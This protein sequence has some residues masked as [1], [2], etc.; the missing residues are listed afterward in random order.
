M[1]YNRSYY[2]RS[3][4]SWRAYDRSWLAYVKAEENMTCPPQGIAHLKTLVHLYK[5]NWSRTQEAQSTPVFFLLDSIA[6]LI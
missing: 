6:R 1:P 3:E 2:A 5:A 4:M